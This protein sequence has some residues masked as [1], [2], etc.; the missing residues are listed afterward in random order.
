[1]SQAVEE[2]SVDGH[3]RQNRTE[4]DLEQRKRI[5]E[6]N[7]ESGHAARGHEEGTD[8]HIGEEPEANEDVCLV[9]RL[10]VG[11]HKVCA[12]PKHHRQGLR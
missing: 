4:V 2:S 1:M 12:Q 10:S 9:V 5:R 11:E 7:A 6:G 8:R 3:A